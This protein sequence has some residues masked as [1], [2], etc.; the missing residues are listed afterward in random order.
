MRVMNGQAEFRYI[1]QLR[2]VLLA[3]AT[4]DTPL[5]GCDRLLANPREHRL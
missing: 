4:R 1:R 2:V 3:I 5:T